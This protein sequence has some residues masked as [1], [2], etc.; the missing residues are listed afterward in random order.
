MYLFKNTKSR[1]GKEENF[2]DIHG[3]IHNLSPL[4]CDYLRYRIGK[5]G[6]HMAYGS[7]QFNTLFVLMCGSR[8]GVLPLNLILTPQPI[9]GN[10]LLHFLFLKLCSVYSVLQMVF[11][12]TCFSIVSSIQAVCK[13]ESS[14]L[15][16]FIKY[17]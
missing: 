7:S 15:V 4:E 17:L 13:I 12:I 16:L 9:T 11:L 2:S 14:S 10:L 5:G 8:G 6:A 1:K 3:V